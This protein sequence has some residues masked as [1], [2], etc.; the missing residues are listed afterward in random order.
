M[1]AK[2][3]SNREWQANNQEHLKSYR[4]ANQEHI[5]ERQRRYL[6][7]RNYGLEPKE[8]EALTQSTGGKCAVCG[9]SDLRL[10]IDHCHRTGKVGSLVCS[11]CNWLVSY[12]ENRF[13]LIE[14]A[15]EYVRKYRPRLQS[16]E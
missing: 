4:E 9:R 11:P 10:N 5:R 16:Q 6:A 2:I 3:A 1:D 13:D 14:A 12:V 15:M 8:F 7:K